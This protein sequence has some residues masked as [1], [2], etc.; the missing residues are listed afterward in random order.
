MRKVRGGAVSRHQGVAAR[1]YHTGIQ[2]EQREEIQNRFMGGNLN[3]VV[4]TIAFGMGIDKRNIRKVIHYNQ[5]KSSEGY[6]QEI[7]RA[8]RDG[9]VSVCTLT[10]RYTYFERYLFKRIRTAAEIAGTFSVDKTAHRLSDLF[11]R[12]E[13][14]DV[15]RIHDMI[16]LFESD[17]CLAVELSGHFGETVRQ[18]GG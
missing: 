9:Q 11:G 10:P 14:A 18:P 15:Q 13:S 3:T 1:A 12:K 16:A 6:S 5:P 7:G 2:I 8:G 4:A 17:G